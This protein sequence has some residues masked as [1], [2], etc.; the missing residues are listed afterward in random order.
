MNTRRGRKGWAP[1]FQGRAPTSI[2][3]HNLLASNRAGEENAWNPR[4]SEWKGAV[5]EFA[6]LRSLHLGVLAL[7]DVQRHVAHLAFRDHSRS[8]YERGR[9]LRDIGSN[10]AKLGQTRGLVWSRL[11][12]FGPMLTGVKPMLVDA[13]PSLVDSETSLVQFGDFPAKLGRCRGMCC[14][15]LALC[16]RTRDDCRSIFANVD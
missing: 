15:N 12:G 11:A 13:T 5:Q 8:T 6:E 4:H 1:I 16:G 3:T 14:P 2:S 7:A 9:N 10:S